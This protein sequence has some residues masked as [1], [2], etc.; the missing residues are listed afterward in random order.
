MTIDTKEERATADECCEAGHLIRQVHRLA[1]EVDRLLR[2]NANLCNAVGAFDRQLAEKEEGSEA[3]ADGL[4]T[5]ADYAH[6]VAA[7]RDALAARL[8]GVEAERDNAEA[9]FAR[10]KARADNTTIVI[11]NRDMEVAGL[12]ARCT[13][14]EAE[15]D[16]ALRKV[17]AIVEHAAFFAERLTE[18]RTVGYEDG[19]R[20]IF[21]RGG[22]ERVDALN[23]TLADTSESAARFVDLDSEE[24]RNWYALSLL[25]AVY[26]GDP[27]RLDAVRE[28]ADK[29]VE[30]FK[31]VRAKAGKP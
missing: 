22:H 25:V 16:E 8:K 24:F 20:Y 9:L 13:K 18:A 15:R 14:A 4:V 3:L 5:A 6:D 10:E 7:E 19:Y 26:G 11:G 17:A 30:D 23:S 28:A 12:R 29:T 27:M 2:E 21:K 31:V 1:D